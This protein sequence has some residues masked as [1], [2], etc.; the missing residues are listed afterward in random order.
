MITAVV[1]EIRRHGTAGPAPAAPNAGR[2]RRRPSMAR[3]RPR[4]GG[5]TWRARARRWW[6][7]HSAPW[8]AIWWHT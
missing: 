4:R 2:P 7:S 1:T 3:R 6:L 5:I 8:R